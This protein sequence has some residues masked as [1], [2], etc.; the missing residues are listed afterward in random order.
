MLWSL[1]LFAIPIG[2][3]IIEVELGV[4]RFP[5]QPLLAV[6]LLALSTLLVLWAAMTL[7]VKGHGTPLPLAPTRELV[8]TGPYA[9]MRHPFVA[10]LTG[11]IVALGVALGSVP[12]LVYAVVAMAVWYYGIRPGE[13]RQ[14]DQRF[15]G[16]V[17]Q[18][19]RKVRGFRP[20]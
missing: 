4:Q 18:Y 17:Q 12:V 6:P 15:G 16:R 3:S 10:G 1:F 11:Q 5:A 13:E 19:R 7:A 14:L 8:T 2:I 20:F 9:F